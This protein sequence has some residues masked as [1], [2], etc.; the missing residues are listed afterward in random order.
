MVSGWSSSLKGGGFML[1]SQK[2]RAQG[3]VE[4]ALLILLIA[5]VVILAVTLMGSDLS[6]LYSRIVDAWPL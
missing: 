4:Y 2:E 1:N 5:L 3:M 6:G